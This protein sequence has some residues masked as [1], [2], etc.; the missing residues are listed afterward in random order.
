MKISFAAL[1]NGATLCPLDIR[2]RGVT[3]I[4]DW[5]I[6]QEVTIL[7]SVPI[8]FRQFAGTLTGQEFFPHL[9]IIQLGSDL[10]TPRELKEYQRHFSARTILVV[11]FGTTETGTVRRMYFDSTSSLEEAQN[12]VGYAVEGAEVCLTDDT[13]AALP[14]DAVG[15]IVVKGGY[16]SPGY[17]R[18]PDLSREKFVVDPNG[19][20]QRMYYTG[21]LGRLRAD[22]RLYHLGR[23]D[24]QLSVRGYRVETGEIEVLLLAQPNVKEALVATFGP[25]TSA[26]HDR[27]VAY[28]V[29]FEKPLPVISALRKAVREK[30]PA[31]MVPTDFI[32]LD[33][34]PLT[35]GGKIDRS[36]LPAPRGSRPDL[37]VAY[38]APRSDIERLLAE[39]WAEVLAIGPVGIH[40]DFFALGGHSLA[41]T[42]IIS[43]MLQ[44]SKLDLPIT[45]LFDAPTVA[46]MAEVVRQNQAHPVDTA[47]LER[48]LRVAETMTDE[49]AQECV[50]EI[51][52]RA[53]NK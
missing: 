17:W 8:L 6:R 4:S 19:G 30:L 27:L 46:R 42:R 28:I 11:R 51:N 52:S 13:G 53:A 3:Q 5:L 21:D 44:K 34:L 35:P 12:A 10:V 32:F 7:F 47:A 41:A 50:N 2:K 23:K 38:T 36:A 9:R 14:I 43:R 26:D 39:I 37:E 33:S 20:D 22:G 24:F 18:R 15:E 25:S 48:M 1:L 49:E 29:A 31:H 40:D 16:L 45:A